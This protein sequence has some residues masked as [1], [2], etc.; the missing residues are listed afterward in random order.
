MKLTFNTGYDLIAKQITYSKIE[1]SRDLHCWE[2]VFSWIPLGNLK[3][4][5]FTLRIK[6]SFLQDVKLEKKTDYNLY[7]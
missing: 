6:A 1:F 2:M 3:S 4:Y 5:N 7:Q